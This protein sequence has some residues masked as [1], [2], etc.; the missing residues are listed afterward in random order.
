M[1]YKLTKKEFIQRANAIHENLYNY[2]KVEYNNM[3]T[4]VCIIDPE[5][6]EFWQVPLGHLSGQGHPTR[7]KLKVSQK[8]RLGKDEFVRRAIKKHGNLY[9]YSKVEYTHVDHKVCIIDPEYGEFW[10]SPYQHLNSHGCPLRTTEKKWLNHI[11]HIIPISIVYNSRFSKASKWIKERPLYK[12]LDSDINKQVI[13][14]TE[15]RN[16]SDLVVINN[17]EINASLLRNNY[18]AIGYLIKNLLKVDPSDIINQDKEFF[19]KKLN[20]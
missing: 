5:Y 16:K 9:D 17:L 10:Q 6:G 14:A 13:T 4:K 19:Q 15:N 8:R 1:P 11:D 7:G 18:E 20:F 3:H 2:N 12:F